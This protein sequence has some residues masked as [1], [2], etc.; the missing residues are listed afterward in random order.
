M[1][2][3]NNFKYEDLRPWYIIVNETKGI[4]NEEIFF[5]IHHF[6]LD[7]IYSNTNQLNIIKNVRTW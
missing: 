7:F 3:K 6:K 1:T 2:N 5:G 4:Y